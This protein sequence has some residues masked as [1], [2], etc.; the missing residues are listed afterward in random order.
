MKIHHVIDLNESIEK[1]FDAKHFVHRAELCSF[2]LV[3]SS[4][5]SLGSHKT[6]EG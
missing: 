2:R 1:H 4:S 3:I 5:T 6:V